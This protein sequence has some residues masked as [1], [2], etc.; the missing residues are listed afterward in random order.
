MSSTAAAQDKNLSICQANYT[1]GYILYI[2]SLCLCRSNLL[3][4]KIFGIIIKV[5]HASDTKSPQLCPLHYSPCSVLVYTLSN[6]NFLIAI[7]FF[8]HSCCC[9]WLLFCSDEAKAKWNLLLHLLRILRHSRCQQIKN[10][11]T[12]H[13]VCMSNIPTV[14]SSLFS[15]LSPQHLSS[16]CRFASFFT[17]TMYGYFS[18]A[19][20]QQ[21]QQ[22]F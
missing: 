17:Q 8:M 18:I 16:P 4:A 15:L 20:Q 3:V 11:R 12:H 21:Q 5:L 14:S 13:V 9:C 10:H 1:I 19:C 7:T 22:Q 6:C 2:Y